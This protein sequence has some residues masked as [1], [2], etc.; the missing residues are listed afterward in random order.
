MTTKYE[1]GVNVVEIYPHS[2]D[3]LQKLIAAKQD[4]YN[5]GS[6]T[7]HYKDKA[8]HVHWQ[9]NKPLEL[10]VK[11]LFKEMTKGY[12]LIK[13]AWTPPLD[14]FAVLRKPEKTIKAELLEVVKL[15]RKEYDQSRFE[16]NMA[17][18]ERQVKFSVDQVK[19]A[20]EAAVAEEAAK[21]A[22]ALKQVQEAA[23]LADLLK[24]YAAPA[25]AT[26]EEKAA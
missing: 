13:M 18:T 25:E 9:C 11:D 17:E 26:A 7:L 19:R 3:D 16:L 23:A 6:E 1:Y 21:A 5:R 22:A 12:E 8:A 20:K 10:A 24:A 15:A 2:D 4:S 14:F